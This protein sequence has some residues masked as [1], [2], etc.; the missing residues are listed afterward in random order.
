MTA[1]LQIR[2]L[3]AEV[4]GKQIIDG[5]GRGLKPYPEARGR[6]QDGGEEVSG[7]F[8]VAGRDAAEVLQLVEEAFDEIALSIDCAVDRALNLAVTAGRDMSPP[9]A[10]F[11]QID[12]GASIISAIGD[13]I[14]AG[15]DLFDQC[16]CHRLVRRLARRQNDSHRQ[17]RLVDDG[18]DLGAQSSTRT[19]N[20]VIRTPFFPPAACW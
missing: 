10:A 15:F 4:A 2:D 12:Q 7:R 11:D 13:E 19:A 5:L 8:V 1:L 3:R 16:R 6:E 18:I 20:G 17:A 14:A 9:A